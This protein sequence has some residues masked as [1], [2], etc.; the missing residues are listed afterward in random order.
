MMLARPVHASFALLGD[1]LA[2][3][4]SCA[5]IQAPRIGLV[6]F[7][8][9]LQVSKL[10]MIKVAFQKHLLYVE[11]EMYFQFMSCQFLLKG[12]H[13]PCSLKFCVQGHAF[14]FVLY[15]IFEVTFMVMIQWSNLARGLIPVEIHQ[16]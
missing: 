8:Q 16:E 7:E 13:V 1:A 12:H 4:A 3:A 5:G 14:L 9:F 11:I 6:E 15:N 10:Y 2:W